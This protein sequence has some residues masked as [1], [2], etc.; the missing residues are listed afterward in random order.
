[1]LNEIGQS[2]DKTAAQVAL[3]WAI[4]QDAIVPIPCSTN[5]ARIAENVDI[6]DFALTGEEMARIDTLKRP[7][8]RIA[9]PA[10]RAPA[11]DA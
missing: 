6:F 4:Q 8:S 3:R 7:G 11:W 9:D 5:A 2:R 1:V 10:G